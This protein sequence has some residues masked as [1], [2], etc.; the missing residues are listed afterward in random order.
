MKLGKYCSEQKSYCAISLLSHLYKLLEQLHPNL[1][2]PIIEIHLIEEQA[3]SIL[4]S[5]HQPVAQHDS[6]A[7]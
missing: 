1:L 5:D 3:V 7:H 2:A 4:V 6:L